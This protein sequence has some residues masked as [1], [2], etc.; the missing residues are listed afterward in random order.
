MAVNRSKA[1]GK[2]TINIKSEPIQ[3]HIGASKYSNDDWGTVAYFIPRSNIQKQFIEKEL[4]YA[5]IYFLV[6]Y[7]GNSEKIYVGQGKVRNDGSAV[8]S[9]LRGIDKNF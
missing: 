7:E 5:G 9:R 4:Q 8:L 6:G 2:S 3:G 1:L